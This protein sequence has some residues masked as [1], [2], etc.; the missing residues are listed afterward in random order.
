MIALKCPAAQ[1]KKE[2]LLNGHPI[3]TF[4]PFRF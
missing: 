1:E 2:R 3:K 4:P